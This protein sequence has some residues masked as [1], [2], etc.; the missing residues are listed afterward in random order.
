MSF[1]ER[2]HGTNHSLVLPD[3]LVMKKTVTSVRRFRV[4]DSTLYF[5]EVL[6][7]LGANESVAEADAV[8]IIQFETALANVSPES[9]N[10]LSIVPRLM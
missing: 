10:I 3:M 7:L 8:Q 2:D 4:H 1:R 5:R 9:R 6:G